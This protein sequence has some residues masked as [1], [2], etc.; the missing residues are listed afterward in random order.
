MKRYLS[1]GLF[2]AS[3]CGLMALATP[4]QAGLGTVN[5]VSLNGFRIYNGLSSTNGFRVNGFKYNG[6]RFNGLGTVNGFRFNGLSS[7][8]GSHLQTISLENATQQL[9]AENGQLVLTVQPN[10]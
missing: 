4:A 10:P 7:F 3:I 8:N 1:A 9:K 6:F 5:G 2:V